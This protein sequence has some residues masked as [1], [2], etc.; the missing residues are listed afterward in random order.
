MPGKKKKGLSMSERKD[1]YL[2]PLQSRQQAVRDYQGDS[3]VNRGLNEAYNMG[4]NPTDENVRAAVE[5]AAVKSVSSRFD[6]PFS[7]QVQAEA[8]RF[9]KATQH[10]ELLGRSTNPATVNKFNMFTSSGTTSSMNRN[11][12]KK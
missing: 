11:N 5:N 6:K 2:N 3:Y 1:Q 10:D 12:K 7:K 4:Y 9:D 8:K